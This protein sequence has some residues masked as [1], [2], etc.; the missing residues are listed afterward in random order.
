MDLKGVG[1]WKIELWN[2]KYG[3]GTLSKLFRF[4][5]YNFPGFKIHFSSTSNMLFGQN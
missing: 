1:F 2:P 5:G 4:P 3:S